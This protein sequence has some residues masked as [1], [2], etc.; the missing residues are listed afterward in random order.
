[1][2]DSLLGD[3]ETQLRLLRFLAV[4]AGSALVQVAAIVDLVADLEKHGVT[5]APKAYTP[6]DPVDWS[7][8][9]VS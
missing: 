2:F 3:R 9:R 1:M 8:G 5:L 7:N 4:G 6:G